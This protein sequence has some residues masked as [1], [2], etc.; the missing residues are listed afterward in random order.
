MAIFLQYEELGLIPLGIP[1]EIPSARGEV[2]IVSNC[3]TLRH[4]A[5]D[6]LPVCITILLRF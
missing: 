5:S 6:F 2:K 4:L 3:A 1:P